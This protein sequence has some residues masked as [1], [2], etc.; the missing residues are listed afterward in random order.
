MLV[1]WIDPG[2]TTIW[3]ALVEKIWNDKRLLDYWIIETTPKVPLKNKL[4]EI[5][6]DLNEILDNYDVDKA[7]I[8]KLF[9]TN[10]ITTWID[11]AWARWVI[12]LELAKR[13]III[14]EYTP[15]QLKKAVCWNGKAKK[16][17]LQNAIKIHF[18]LDEIPK[19]DDAADAVWLAYMWVLFSEKLV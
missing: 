1:L 2:T 6:S 19:P 14:E 17:Q 12:I 8:E 16:I 18:G 11:V 3:Y 4:L 13:N 7:V 10:N 9:F 5:Y 15:L